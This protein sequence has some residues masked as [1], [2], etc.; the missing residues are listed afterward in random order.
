MAVS[1]GVKAG[2]TLL[3][4]EGPAEKRRRAAAL[5]DAGAFALT[6]SRGEREK[7]APLLGEMDAELGSVA[8]GFYEDSQRLSLLPKGEG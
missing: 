4:F 1:F 7:R 6:L 2:L 8:N 3:W 5:P